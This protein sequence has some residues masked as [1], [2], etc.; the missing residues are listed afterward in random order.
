MTSFGSTE[1]AMA[2]LF[3]DKNFTVFS[4]F[5]DFR[6]DRRKNVCLSPFSLFDSQ[7][8][9]NSRSTWIA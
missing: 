7:C 3:N 5:P 8:I 9:I 4:D 1:Q 2:M 6:G